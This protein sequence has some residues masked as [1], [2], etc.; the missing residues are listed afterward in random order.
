IDVDFGVP[1]TEPLQLPVISP[2]TQGP[3]TEAGPGDDR[4]DPPASIPDRQATL[5]SSPR[6]LWRARPISFQVRKRGQD[7]FSGTAPTN[8]RSMPGVL[9]K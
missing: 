3:A 5:E 9:H 7:S 1:M 4:L 8:L 6:P 2:D